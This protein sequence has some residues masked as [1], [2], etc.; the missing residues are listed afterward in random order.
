MK[1]YELLDHTADA[2][3]RAYGRTLEEVFA[4]AVQGMTA[5]VADP[6]Q[7]GRAKSARITVKG[8][9]LEGLL[10]NML[11][12]IL[13]LHDTE[14]LLPAAAEQLMIRA[15]EQGFVLEATLVGDD[16]R[17][18]PGNL[19]AV[20]YS[21]MIVEQLPDKTWLIQAVIDI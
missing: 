14:H 9:T 3:F 1:P 4:N 15:A 16:S 11:D 2:K 10:F 6:A 21:E 13:F 5:I 12:E 20:T 18:W 17:R 19:K 7:L 8:K